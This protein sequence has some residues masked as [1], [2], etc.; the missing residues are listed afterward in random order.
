MKKVKKIKNGFISRQISITKLALKTGTSLYRSRNKNPVKMLSEGLEG[1]LELIVEE[2]GLMK[3]SLM[4][5]GQALSVYG[6]GFLPE[7]MQKLL[8][9]LEKETNYLD[10][11]V[12]KET[13]P[14]SWR[15][16]LLITP[17]P[18]AA[19]SIGQVHLAMKDKEKYA[20]KIQYQGVR[21]A[22]NND[23][24]SLKFL[25]K[26][27]KVL[28]KEMDFDAVFIEIKTMLELETD[29][30]NEAS[31]T[32]EFK[33]LLKNEPYFRV[34]EVIENYSNESILTT[35]FIDGYNLRDIP[36]D[37][38][39]QEQRNELGKQFM[40]LL[41]LELFVFE[42]VQSDVHLGNYLIVDIESSP[43]WGLIDFGSTKSP[44]KNFIQ[45][46]RNLIVDLSNN[47]RD[48]FLESF[49]EMGYISKKK[50]TN[51]E[52]LWDYA[53]II[54]EPFHSGV[55]DWG[56]SDIADRVFKSIPRIIREISIGN[57]PTE[58]IFLDRKIGGVYF[59]L[60][61][62]GAVFDPKEVLNEFTQ[63]LNRP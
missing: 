49:Y 61:Q 46:Y 34:P 41:F 63:N 47:N 12:I 28:P 44:D 29:Y 6:G 35:E 7:S 3:G 33:K 9:K 14:K 18:L 42:K 16:D 27:L 38:L 58:S 56:N 37:M 2:L 21:K 55:Y 23:I 48:S 32:K 8:A 62:L 43:K 59:V 36:E 22:I 26:A 45:K 52:F 20:M 57:P 51:I 40:R 60:Q 50:E 10:W 30:L 54:G 5:A 1:Q 39:T 15:D 4:K 13:V 31:N 17:R 19:A 24:K 53:A 25:L 11:E